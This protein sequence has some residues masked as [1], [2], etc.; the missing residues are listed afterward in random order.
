MKASGPLAF[1]CAL[2]APLLAHAASPRAQLDANAVSVEV[3]VRGARQAHYRIAPGK[4][5]TLKV[6]GPVNVRFALRAEGGTPGQTIV[7][8][9]ELDGNAAAQPSVS[10]VV[11]AQATSDRG[12]AVSQAARFAVSV[13]EGKHTVV[14]RWPSSAAADGLAAVGGVRISRKRAPAEAAS[15]LQ[16]PG[17]PAPKSKKEKRAAAGKAPLTLPDVE[18]SAPATGKPLPLPEIAAAP[19]AAPSAPAPAPQQSAPPA[20]AAV[21][22]PPAAAA[23]PLVLA[24][25]PPPPAKTSPPAADRVATPTVALRSEP[26][27]GPGPGVLTLMLFGGAERSNQDFTSAATVAQFGLEV[28]R[29]LWVSGLALFQFDWRASQQSYVLGQPGS[30]NDASKVD[31]YRYDILAGI[32][33]DFSHL[34]GT[35]GLTAAPIIGLKYIRIANSTFPADLFGVDLMGRLRYSL[36]QAVA[37]HTT[38]GWIYNLVHPSRFSALG[39]PLGQFGVRAGFDFPLAGGYALALDYQG[40]ILTFDFSNRVSHG[41]SAGFGKSF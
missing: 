14:L 10:A 23:A 32:G 1:L 2:L 28:S 33:Y 41:A 25:A 15:P 30:A 24:P 19:K 9:A 13:P 17:A 16:L 27:W 29:A 18:L 26:S 4:A 31:E 39:S 38:F 40:D 3:T 36:S 11:E 22:P 34:L 37:I 5:L 20:A 12:L 21:A 6:T 35:P 8:L 7:A